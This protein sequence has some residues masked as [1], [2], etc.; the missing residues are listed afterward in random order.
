MKILA[1]YSGNDWE[2]ANVAHYAIPDEFN[3]KE[4]L[5]QFVEEKK[6]KGNPSTYDFVDWLREKGIAKDADDCIESIS[7]Y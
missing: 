1:V 7:L 5:A 2:D 6:I 4:L 3:E